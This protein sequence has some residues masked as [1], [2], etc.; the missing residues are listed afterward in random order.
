MISAPKT[1]YSHY[2]LKILRPKVTKNIKNLCKKFCVFLPRVLVLFQNCRLCW[3]V[4]VELSLLN[5][6]CMRGIQLLRF[7]CT[8][9]ST[10]ILTTTL[11][12]M[13]KGYTCKRTKTHKDTQKQ[14]THTQQC[15]HPVVTLQC[16][17]NKRERKS[18]RVNEQERANVCVCVKESKRGR[19]KRE[20]E[21][22]WENVWVV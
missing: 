7:L 22:E 8:K 20:G 12:Y 13:S 17:L 1:T 3:V 2:N 9:S 4:L 16:K 14:Y 6:R 11:V 19:K 10:L 15:V 21:R 18:V 5:C